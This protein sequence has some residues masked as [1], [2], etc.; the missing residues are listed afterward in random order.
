LQEEGEEL[1]K[2]KKEGVLILGEEKEWVVIL[3]EEKTFFFHHDDHFVF[4]FLV[5]LMNV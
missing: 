4:L 2:K 1:W 5:C 3:G